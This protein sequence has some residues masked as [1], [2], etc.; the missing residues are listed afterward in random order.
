M[1]SGD[2]IMTEYNDLSINTILPVLKA[3]NQKQALHIMTGYAARAIRMDQRKL[4]EL[5]S[6]CERDSVSPGIGDGVAIHHLVLQNIREPYILFARAPQPIDY[7]AVDHKP[8][9][10]ISLIISPEMEGAYNLQRLALVSRMLRDRVLCEC[11]R[12]ADSA[13][14]MSALL[15][16]FSHPLRKA[17]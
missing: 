10:L 7:N 3:N 2:Y 11:L 14:A 4:L 12:G 13:D 5:I 17:A 8:V 16:E 15:H 6:A 1:D 9:D